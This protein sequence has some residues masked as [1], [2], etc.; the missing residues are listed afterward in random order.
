[1][2][3][4]LFFYLSKLQRR[5]FKWNGGSDI[6]RMWLKV[7]HRAI[8]CMLATVSL[9]TFLCWGVQL[10]RDPYP[11]WLLLVCAILLYFLFSYAGGH[12]IAGTHIFSSFFES[13]MV[14]AIELCT[15]PPQNFKHCILPSFTNISS[16][17]HFF[18]CWSFCRLVWWCDF[19]KRF[20][21]DAF[22]GSNSFLPSLF[23]LG[24]SCSSF[25]LTSVC[26]IQITST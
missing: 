13:G 23:Y 12:D 26:M 17:F 8:F 24:Q 10:L 3:I 2:F 7:F 22:S 18:L 19:W 4:V 9:F 6:L 11:T 15:S 5:R 20:L 21:S 14:Y 25:Y 16:L 1:M